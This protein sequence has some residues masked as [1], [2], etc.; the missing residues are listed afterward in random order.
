MSGPHASRAS[1]SP[2]V[3]IATYVFSSFCA[4][5]VGIIIASQLEAAAP[6]YGRNL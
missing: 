6:G 3:K 5:L 2:R 4:A 1:A